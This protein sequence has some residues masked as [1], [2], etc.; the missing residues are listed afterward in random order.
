MS[1]WERV[2]T[3]IHGMDQWESDAEWE[4]IGKEFG[5]T[6]CERVCEIDHLFKTLPVSWAEE[7]Y[8]DLPGKLRVFAAQRLSELDAQA[9]Q[10]LI[11]RFMYSWK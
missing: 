1:E 8:E 11:G 5:V 3:A 2:N 4:R 7:H 9:V 10:V 6:V